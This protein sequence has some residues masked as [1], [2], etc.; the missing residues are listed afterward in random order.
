[1]LVALSL[2]FDNG[3]SAGQVEQTV[4]RIEEQIRAAV[5][6]VTHVFIEAQDASAR[7]AKGRQ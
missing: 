5:P 1:V 2:D 4:S 7:L 6:E 3:L